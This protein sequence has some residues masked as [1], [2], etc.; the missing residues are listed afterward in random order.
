MN[1]RPVPP[2]HLVKQ[3]VLK[4][5]SRRFKVKVL[6]ETGT[7]YGD[8]VA[9]MMRTFDH[10][11]TI[12]LSE[13]LYEQARKRFAGEK[14]IT[15]I[16]GDSGKELNSLLERIDQPAL[17]WLDGHYSGGETARGD[18]DSPIY[19][20]LAHILNS[21]EKRHIVIIDDARCFGTD[22]AYPSIEEIAEFVKAKRPD[23]IIAVKDDIIRIIPY[24][25]DDKNDV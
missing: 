8:M 12:E 22:Q 15:L 9:A 21:P 4:T 18:K 24:E 19:E 1:G 7:Y 23:S 3:R 14:K 16:H 25:Q 17:F 13:K 10:I 20:E 11:Y 2:P 6:V 5:F